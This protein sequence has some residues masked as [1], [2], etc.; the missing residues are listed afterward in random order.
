MIIQG[1]NGAGMNLFIQLKLEVESKA[2]QTASRFSRPDTTSETDTTLNLGNN[3]KVWVKLKKR[4]AISSIR[5]IRVFPAKRA[6]FALSALAK[7]AG[8]PIIF[9]ASLHELLYA[10]SIIYI[11]S[12]KPVKGMTC[13]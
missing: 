11:V 8:Y 4:K 9:V 2:K 1:E 12:E 10:V 3:P 5:S 6:F 7:R 13:L